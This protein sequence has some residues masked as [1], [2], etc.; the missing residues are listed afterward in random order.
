VQIGAPAEN[1]T[2]ALDQIVPTSFSCLDDAGAALTGTCTDSN[3][4]SGASGRLDT[5]T[6]G[7]H[8]Y[9]VT[10][11]SPQGDATRTLQYTVVAMAAA[12][13]AP[14]D[15][16]TYTLGQDVPTSFGC[17]DASGAPATGFCTDSNGRSGGNGTLDTSTVG[18]H[19]YA[20]TATSASGQTLT[21][22]I[23]YTVTPL[24]TVVPPTTTAFTVT[25]LE[26]SSS[27]GQMTFS[28]TVPGPGTIKVIE[29]ASSGAERRTQAVGA[30]RRS[31]G[32]RP[33]SGRFVFAV[34]TRA[35]TRAGTV[36]LAVRPTKRGTMLVSHHRHQVR[37][38]LYVTYTP[39]GGTA[40][41]V[42]RLG[43]VVAR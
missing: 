19:T 25:R 41:T 37:V 27:K 18:A 22:A 42:P 43:V 32:A 28:V 6:A 13:S 16:G 31:A 7:A 5:A 29:T 12:I 33:G 17:G 8:A 30:K 1:G 21:R 2:Y 11:T 3:G 9:T 20:V 38:N 36:T 34:T 39:A 4:G 14:A 23:G 26:V 24:A 40:H 15:N 10:A 35:V